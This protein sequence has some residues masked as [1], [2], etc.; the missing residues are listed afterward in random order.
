ML[1]T[2]IGFLAAFTSTISLVPQIYKT[3][4]SRSSKDLSYLMLANFLATS[5]LWVA[6]GLMVS[7]QAVWVANII[8]VVFSTLMLI[9]KYKH[10]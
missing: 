5:M 8:L 10:K 7:S 6:Y 2:F 9:L 1:V 3:Y 4:K